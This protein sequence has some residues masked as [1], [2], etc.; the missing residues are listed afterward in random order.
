MLGR[1]VMPVDVID[2]GE[3][4]DKDMSY[5]RISQARRHVGIDVSPRPLAMCQ[6]TADV[7]TR[8]IDIQ[9]LYITFTL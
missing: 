8:G 4:Q 7:I 2:K 3:I 6:N 1:V 5:E 9:K